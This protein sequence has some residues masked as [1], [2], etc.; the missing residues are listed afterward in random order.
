MKN[1]PIF[2][3]KYVKLIEKENYMV[4]ETLDIVSILPVLPNGDF[5]LINQYRIPIGKNITELVTGGIEKGEN[6]EEAA[7]REVIEETGYQTTSIDYVGKYY[8]AP[9]YITQKAY[10][11]V[12]EISEFVGNALEDH[13]K[14]FNLNTVQV[15]KE[16]MEQ[17]IEKGE[18]HPYLSIAYHHYQ[19]KRDKDS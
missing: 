5:L 18:T 14:T 16:E 4:Y 15:K 3:N 10:V 12:A 13:E 17:L 1:E 2:E 19:N 8:S 11:F 9:G 6:P 7:K